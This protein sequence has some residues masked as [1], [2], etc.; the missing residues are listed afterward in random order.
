MPDILDLTPAQPETLRERIDRDNATREWKAKNDPGFGGA[1]AAGLQQT[2]TRDAFWAMYGG[3]EFETDPSFKMDDKTID[4]LTDGVDRDL[5][6]VFAGSRSMDHAMFLRA[7]ALDIQKNRMDVA[8]AGFKGNV[9][10]VL[11]SLGDPITLA[12]GVASGGAGALA[13]KG[14]QLGI[15]GKIALGAGVG[16]IGNAIPAAVRQAVSPTATGSDLAMDIGLGATLGAFGGASQGLSRTARF[17][18][19]GAIGAGTNLAVGAG[20]AYLTDDPARIAL[21]Y[22]IGESFLLFGTLAALPGTNA[23]ANVRTMNE[24]LAKAGQKMLPPRTIV[25]P[26]N[27]PNAPAP[28]Q[29][30]GRLPAARGIAGLLPEKVKTSDLPITDPAYMLPPRTLVTPYTEK[31]VIGLGPEPTVQ[32]SPAAEPPARMGKRDAVRAYARHLLDTGRFDETSTQEIADTLKVDIAKVQ[33]WT[34]PVVRYHREQFEATK[35][36]GPLFDEPPARTAADVAEQANQDFQN[37][38]PFDMFASLDDVIESAKSAATPDIA[39]TAPDIAKVPLTG[40]RLTEA[41]RIQEQ[42]TLDQRLTK[43]IEKLK[44]KRQSTRRRDVTLGTLG[45]N[46]EIGEIVDIAHEAV[47][48]AIRAGVRTTEAIA[49]HIADIISNRPGLESVKADIARQ[50]IRFNQAESESALNSIYQRAASQPAPEVKPSTKGIYDLDLGAVSDAPSIMVG[51]KDVPNPLGTGNMRV[52]TWRFGMSAVLSSSVDSLTRWVSNAVGQDFLPKADGKG[53]FSLS[54]WVSSRKKAVYSK[55]THAYD[56]VYAKYRKSV[57]NPLSEDEFFAAAGKFRRGITD[58]IEPE[59]VQFLKDADTVW[60]NDLTALTEMAVRHGVDGAKDFD[61]PSY[62]HRIWS[63]QAV[64]DA[65]NTHGME[66]VTEALTQAIYKKEWHSGQRDLFDA[67]M[68]PLATARSLARA[69]IRHALRNPDEHTF[70]MGDILDRQNVDKLA[71]TLRS[72]GV[73]QDVIA[74]IVHRITHDKADAGKAKPFRNRI[75]MDEAYTHT[76]P[77]G[78]SISVADLMV[79][80]IRHLHEHF[81]NHMIS[82]SSLQELHYQLTRRVNGLNGTTMDDYTPPPTHGIVDSVIAMLKQ[83]TD[84]DPASP[85]FLGEL[86][87][88]KHMIQLAAG[89][90]TRKTT[91]FDRVASSIRQLNLIRSLASIPSAA[92]Q[93]TDI[94]ES[95]AHGGAGILLNRITGIGELYK[96]LADGQYS[97]QLMRE[98]QAF[99][100]A[101]DDIYSRPRPT[102]DGDTGGYTGPT[103]DRVG[104]FHQGASKIARTVLGPFRLANDAVRRITA[105]ILIDKA[106]SDAISEAPISEKRLGDMGITMEQWNAIKADIAKHATTENGQLGQP[107]ASLNLEKWDPTNAARFHAV[108]NRLYNS[109]VTESNA[110]AMSRWMTTPIGAILTQLRR[111]AFIS[112]DNKLLRSLYFRDVQAFNAAMSNATLNMV[113]RAGAVVYGAVGRPDRDEYI[114]KE[115]NPA[116]LAVQSL[117]RSSFMGIIPIAADTVSVDILGR[118]A[119]FS[120]ARPS[121]ITGGFVLGNPTV[122]WFNSSVKALASIQAPAFSDYSFS[123]EDVRNIRKAL[124]VPDVFGMH[125]VIDALSR[126]LRLPERSKPIYEN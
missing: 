68:D 108:M 16:V 58:N 92:Q 43:K 37:P 2:L 35:L 45:G 116:R 121:G 124:W 110:T 72:E 23:P 107:V 27:D 61:T 104:A 113:A 4:T 24:R 13:T 66:Q 87:K 48:R 30:Q 79:N 42:L 95:L 67:A 99:G 17:L 106:Y 120:G 54:E 75:D 10:G 102:I 78:L 70:V 20:T 47:L 49:Q 89:I 84:G 21:N 82:A 122:D 71:E 111:F 85:V 98:I 39:P 73:A 55:A 12:A 125:R 65:I 88:L 56:A 40:D 101:V 34:E 46:V 44:A 25:T 64:Q 1:F 115:L 18:G 96:T 14:A 105:A 93:L 90:P 41:E 32:P 22:S 7:N 69:V 118:N 109:M 29:P 38:V 53:V 76:T 19:A 74:S 28:T 83:N 6:P 15:A 60:A 8:A 50:A 94:S 31:P 26:W 103:D 33:K 9:A 91:L 3:S 114:R 126:Q 5:W 52:G 11:A 63:S 81:A 112:H 86:D 80:D 59:T 51:A 119:I 57:A 77:N 123:Q 97:S 36:A 62:L 117:G 100:L